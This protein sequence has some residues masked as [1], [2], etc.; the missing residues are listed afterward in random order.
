MSLNG[1]AIYDYD[2]DCIQ[3]WDWEACTLVQ[4]HT[5]IHMH[6]S[7]IIYIY[8]NYIKFNTLTM[9]YKSEVIVYTLFELFNEE[10]VTISLVRLLCIQRSM[11][12][13]N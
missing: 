9:K 3:G 11:I 2:Y 4:L 7:K 12:Y 5:I 8:N 10:F 13:M 1:I 6:A